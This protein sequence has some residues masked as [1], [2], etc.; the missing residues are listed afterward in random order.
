MQEI[1]TIII[2]SGIL[3][4]ALTGIFNLATQVNSNKVLKQIEKSKYQNEIT[5]Y[6]Y[7][8][9]HAFLQ[10]ITQMSNTTFDI[11]EQG[12]PKTVNAVTERFGLIKNKYIAIKPLLEDSFYKSLDEIIEKENTMSN[13]MVEQ[14]YEKEDNNV[15]LKDLLQVRLEFEQTLINNVQD[16]LSTILIRT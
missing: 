4:T 11:S 16:Q 13:A 14:I 2:S 5:H 6:R 9:L 10:S 7:V 1:V 3:V 8:Q 12:L 15:E